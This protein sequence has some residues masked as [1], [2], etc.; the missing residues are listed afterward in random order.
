LMWGVGDVAQVGA[1]GSVDWDLVADWSRRWKLAVV[2][3]RALELT[4]DVLGVTWPEEVRAAI[5]GPV[6]RAAERAMAAYAPG[7]RSRGGT[8]RATFRAIPGV[9]AKTAYAR[10]LLFPQRPF[11]ARRSG[12]SWRRLTIPVRWLVE[13]VHGGPSK[14]HE[15]EAEGV[16]EAHVQEVDS[17]AGTLTWNE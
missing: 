16:T 12:R 7:R 1:A 17:F 11:I 6:D 5:G 14:K 4:E 2:V 10:A 15:I 3:G 8:A 9:R 13:S